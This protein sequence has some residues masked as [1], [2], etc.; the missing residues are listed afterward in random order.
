MNN[1]PLVSI[2]ILVFNHANY[3]R[4]TI[5]SVL[6]QKT[7]FD[8]EII[9]GDDASTDGSQEIIKE[10]EERNPDQI[11]AVLRDK[12]LFG[13]KIDNF[14]DLRRRCKGKYMICLEGDDFWTDENK[15]QKQVDFLES[16]PDYIAT[17][18]STQ[19]VDKNSEPIDEKYPECEEDEYSLNHF[20]SEI[21]PGQ[22]TTILHRNHYLDDSFDNSCFEEGLAVK[23]RLV[24]F[25][26]ASHGKIKCS[27]EKMSSYRHVKEEGSSYSANYKYD[28]EHDKRLY[29]AMIKASKDCKD[30]NA[31]DIAE[32]LYYK[33]LMQGLKQKQ[34]SKKDVKEGRDSLD[35]GKRAR[36]LYFKQWINHHLLHKK[37]WV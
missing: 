20:A 27:K 4:E 31:K 6:M 11:K 28:F 16:H 19:V 21:M 1:Q 5:D 15:L 37:I 13:S 34:C 18:H 30:A 23:D 33:N 7:D 24:F 8:Y 14:E 17:A 9:I 2:Y 25:Y 22:L 32:M 35:N 36:R 29:S 10:Y 12:N 3:L 26:L